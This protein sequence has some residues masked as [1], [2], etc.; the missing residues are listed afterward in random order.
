MAAPVASPVT[1]RLELVAQH[2]NFPGAPTEVV[3][4]IEPGAAKAG[5]VVIDYRA[6]DVP[7]SALK[8]WAR[9]IL[10]A[11]EQTE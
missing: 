8:Q 2:R 3:V 9:S 7:V 6:G 4:E 11:L 10:A 5:L 1:I